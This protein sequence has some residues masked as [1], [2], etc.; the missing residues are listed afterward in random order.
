MLTNPNHI[1]T[2]YSKEQNQS[3]VAPPE[4]AEVIDIILSKEHPDYKSIEDIGKIKFRRT[5]SNTSQNEGNLSIATPKNPNFKIYPLIHEIVDIYT[6]AGVS[7]SVIKNATQY[8][9]SPPVNVWNLV[10]HNALPNASSYMGDN[11][12]NTS[13]TTGNYQNFTGN[14]NAT[15]NQNDNI[16][17]G[18]SF[19]EK[20]VPQLQPFEGDIVMSGR[21]GNNIRLGSVNKTNS[22]TWSNRGTIGDPITIITNSKPNSNEDIKTEDINK[23]SSSIYLCDGQT[24]PIKATSKSMKS[25]QSKPTYFDKYNNNQVII[26]S[27]RILFHAKTDSIFLN[28][29]S[30][31]GMSSNNTVNIDADKG[32]YF[33]SPKLY[34]NS[35]GKEPLIK[36]KKFNDEIVQPLLQELGKLTV[37]TPMGPATLAPNHILIFTQL[38]AKLQLMLSTKVFI[39]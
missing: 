31:I 6:S 24:I 4:S 37:L 14:N 23:D 27:G 38:I 32:I 25:Y 28:A 39:E 26:D 34:L 7:T 16:K 21:W 17:F 19:K 11:K 8:Y 3:S 5:N 35:K 33:E 15:T 36:G 22:N 12:P 13:P 29:K 9:Y 20:I 30:S 1:S 10:N 2:N 18:D